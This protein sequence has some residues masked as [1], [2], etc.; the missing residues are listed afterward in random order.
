LLLTS[1]EK[2]FDQSYQQHAVEHRVFGS[3][4]FFANIPDIHHGLNH[5]ALVQEAVGFFLSVPDLYI[6]IGGDSGNHSSKASKGNQAEEY[7]C[8]DLQMEMLAEDLRPLAEAGRI[9]YI[10]E[11]NHGAGRTIDTHNHSPEKYLATLLY[12]KDYER[13]F[14]KE[15]AF[16][17]FN[18]NKNCYVHY[19]T[20]EGRKR[21]TRLL[22][23]ML[24]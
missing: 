3:R 17:Y 9:L 18:V 15:M 11:G 2:L 13:V 8:G 7:A 23:L 24:T 5:R 6:G 10:I 4:A 19:A 12:G 14:K 22:G 20:H 16:V 1:K 21:T